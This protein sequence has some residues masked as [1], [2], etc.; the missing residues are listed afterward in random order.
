MST[1]P[2]TPFTSNDWQY[3]GVIARDQIASDFTVGYSAGDITCS[4]TQKGIVL[5][6]LTIEVAGYNGDQARVAGGIWRTSSEALLSS[7]PIKTLFNRTGG[8][9]SAQTFAIDSVYLQRH[10]TSG[11]TVG[12][13]AG[14]WRDNTLNTQFNFN[15]AASGSGIFIDTSASSIGAFTKNSTFDSTATLIYSLTYTKVSD[16][17]YTISL[18]EGDGGVVTATISG[19]NANVA[20]SAYLDWGDGQVDYWDIAASAGTQ[21]KTHTYTLG[22]SSTNAFTVTLDVYLDA[23]IMN[24]DTWTYSTTG[25][26]TL[27]KCLRVY[28]GTSWTY[29]FPQVYTSTSSSTQA[30]VLVYNGTSWIGAAT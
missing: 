21:T 4:S 26:V 11:Q 14:F 15:N 2:S 30:S 24:S 1:Y 22:A 25:S 8:N 16:P 27:T 9:A 12:Y 19:S 6:G 10:G 29:S 28:N 18:S 23:S 13:L 7:S 20:T 3:Y 5:T 17:T